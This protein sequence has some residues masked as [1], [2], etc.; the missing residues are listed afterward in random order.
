MAPATATRP[1]IHPHKHPD[2]FDLG[3]DLPVHR[4]GYGAMQIAGDGIWGPPA[5]HA[6]AISVPRAAVSKE[7]IAEALHPY[8]DSVV[9][10]AAPDRSRRRTRLS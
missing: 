6:G 7:L 8:S 5:A 10:P 2:T 4:L 1:S 9:D 3:G